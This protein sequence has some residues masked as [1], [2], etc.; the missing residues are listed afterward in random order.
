MTFFL[1]RLIQNYIRLLILIMVEASVHR[2]KEFVIWNS[3]AYQRLID[4]LPYW[5]S[6]FYFI[7]FY[8]YRKLFYLLI[9]VFSDLFLRSISRLF[10]L[11]ITRVANNFIWFQIGNF[12]KILIWYLIFP[13]FNLNIGL[14]L[15]LT[16]LTKLL[17]FKL[18][19]CLFFLLL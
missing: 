1:I 6:F 17:Y 15:F 2:F 9:I 11:L 5:W 16:N 12:D 7:F 8:N 13:F 3:P 19:F 18:L 14:Y 10:T 4:D